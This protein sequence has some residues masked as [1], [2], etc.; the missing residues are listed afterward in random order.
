MKKRILLIAAATA[1]SCAVLLSGC[2]SSSTSN[3]IALS[4]NWYR[5]T[6]YKYI[7]PTFIKDNENFSAEKLTYAVTFTAPTTGNS[8]YSVEYEDGTYKTEFYATVF[9]IDTL[10]CEKYRADYQS[11]AGSEGIAVYYYKT[12]LSIPSVTFKYKEKTKTFENESI[13]TECYF[14][15]CADYLRPLYSFQ[16]IKSNVPAIYQANSLESTY[17]SV[18]SETYNYYNYKGSAVYSISTDHLNDDEVTEN[19]QKL[20]TSANIFDNSSLDIAIRAMSNL[21]SSLSQTVRLFT[22]ESG[23]QSYSLAGATTPLNNTDSENITALLKTAGLFTD[24]AEDDIPGEVDTV[25]VKLTNS[26]TSMEGVTHTFWYAAIDNKQNNTGRA[27]L[28][29]FTTPLSFGVGTLNYTLSA[30]ESTLWSA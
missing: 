17:H 15:P 11:A 5:Q 22:P 18:D 30:I 13:I 26:N 10:T 21:S 29:K 24:N 9:D 27:T 2:S 6:T 14:L 8:S 23:V 19:T 4:S 28:L 1:A 20:S 25:A 12:E 3:L 7:Q 16:K